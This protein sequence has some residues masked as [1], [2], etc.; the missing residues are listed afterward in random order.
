MLNQT[1]TAPK[2][3]RY[4]RSRACYCVLYVSVEYFY[5]RWKN[6]HRPNRNAPST[7]VVLITRTFHELLYKKEFF[8]IV[9]DNSSCECVHATQRYCTFNYS[10]FLASSSN[11]RTFCDLFFIYI[12]FLVCHPIAKV[13]YYEIFE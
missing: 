9:A 4:R 7:I 10:D 11:P 8:L 3:H 2:H 1:R 12:I 6:I 13:R 5:A